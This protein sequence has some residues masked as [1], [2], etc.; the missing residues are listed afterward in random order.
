MFDDMD[1]MKQALARQMSPWQ[2]H[3][4]FAVKLARQ[5]LSKSYT[6][7]PPVTG[8]LLISAHILDPVQKLRSWRKWD[9]QM[10]INPE[11]ETSY[12]T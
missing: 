7:V 10:D 12:T 3:L 2:E 1:G 6:Q 5:T 11:D 9:K 4:Y 8:M